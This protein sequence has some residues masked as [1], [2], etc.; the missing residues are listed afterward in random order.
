LISRTADDYE[1]L[2]ERAQDP[3]VS[4]AASCGKGGLVFINS[5]M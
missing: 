2:A 3:G 5:A 1:K 4:M